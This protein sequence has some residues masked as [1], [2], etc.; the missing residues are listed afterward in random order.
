MNG[1]STEKVRP[2]LEHQAD[3]VQNLFHRLLNAVYTSLLLVSS[4]LVAWV[5]ASFSFSS[6]L[7]FATRRNGVGR[8]SLRLASKLQV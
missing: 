2:V 5:I 3:H 6:K 7:G 4:H 8:A 1:S